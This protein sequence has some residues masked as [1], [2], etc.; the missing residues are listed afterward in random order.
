MQLLLIID[1]IFDWARDQYR[2]SIRSYLKQMT[3]AS[4][5]SLPDT[6]IAS[7]Q[8]DQVS[9]L[10][11]DR[12]M[13]WMDDKSEH[14]SDSVS[15]EERPEDLPECGIPNA[16]LEFDSDN[17]AIR[18]ASHVR[19]QAFALRIT[20]EN[21]DTLMSA[22]P[23]DNRAKKFARGIVK[24][25]MYDY[26]RVGSETLDAIEMTW[27]GKYRDRDCFLQTDEEF[28][29]KLRFAAYLS[30]RWE[31]TRELNYVAVSQQAVDA[32][33][34]YADFSERTTRKFLDRSRYPFLKTEVLDQFCVR[35]RKSSQLLG[36]TIARASLSSTSTNEPMPPEAIIETTGKRTHG[37]RPSKGLDSHEL[38]SEVYSIHKIGRREISESCKN[39][40]AKSSHQDFV[41]S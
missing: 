2:P 28:L 4:T 3:R 10:Q 7:L 19:S 35:M 15:F 14:E 16:Y 9:A 40:F 33:L 41:V 32:L 20:V 30:P 23:R 5:A 25:M 22:F 17:G 6:D 1:Y 13:A 31:Q 39:D 24:Y 29:V 27:T 12:I 18:D 36:A 21:I 34:H 11:K 26:W 37:F 38:V 8:G